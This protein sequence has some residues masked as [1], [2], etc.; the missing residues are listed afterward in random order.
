LDAVATVLIFLFER[1]APGT[2]ITT[3]VSETEGGCVACST[4]EIDQ[5]VATL[6][7]GR[8]YAT[9]AVPPPGL[10]AQGTRELVD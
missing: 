10:K 8:G 1:H 7:W 5:A 9:D 2:E 6:C 3:L 4:V